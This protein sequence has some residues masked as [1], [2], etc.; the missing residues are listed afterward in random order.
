MSQTIELPDELFEDLA[1]A[2]RAR[3]LTAAEWLAIHLRVV[4]ASTE[5]RPL[6]ELMI[7]LTAV[8]DSAEG[9]QSTHPTAFSMA[10]A[11]KFQK[12]GLRIP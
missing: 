5:A 11:E 4:D 10:L 2:A 8:I 3:G 6:R 9:A 7:G 1:A 12:Q